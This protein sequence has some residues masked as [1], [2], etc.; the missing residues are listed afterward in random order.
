M[1]AQGITSTG[2]ADWIITKLLGT[3]RDTMLAQVGLGAPCRLSCRVGEGPSGRGTICD[4]ALPFQPH[5]P[6]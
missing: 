5:L 6:A 3:P 1:V 2:G 4:A